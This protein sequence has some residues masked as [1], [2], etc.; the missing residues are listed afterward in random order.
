MH[1]KCMLIINFYFKES[2]GA[3]TESTNSQASSLEI[4]I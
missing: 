2:L 4:L 3:L 1:S